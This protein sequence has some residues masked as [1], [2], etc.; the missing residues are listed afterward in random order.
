MHFVDLVNL[1]F[2]IHRCAGT[3]H[4]CIFVDLVNLNFFIHRCAIQQ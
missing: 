2:F 3:H 1:N 4:L